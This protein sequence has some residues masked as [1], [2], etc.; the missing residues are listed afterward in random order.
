MCGGVA[1]SIV[2]LPLGKGVFVGMD[3]SNSL[4]RTPRFESHALVEIRTSRW[5]LFSTKSAILIDISADGFKIEFVSSLA[6]L[7]FGSKI[8]VSIPLAPFGIYS[9]QAIE[10]VGLVRWFDERNFRCGGIFEKSDIETTTHLEQIIDFVAAHSKSS[11][12]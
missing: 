1:A 3:Q 9:A 11:Q 10:L 6:P 2:E 5:N 4:R 8:R 7:R 12:E